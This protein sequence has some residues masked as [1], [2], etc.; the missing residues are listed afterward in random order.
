MRPLR[1]WGYQEAVKVGKRLQAES[2]EEPHMWR[3]ESCI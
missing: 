2:A 3:Q 1:M